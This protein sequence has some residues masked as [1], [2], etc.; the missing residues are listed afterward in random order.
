MEWCDRKGLRRSLAEALWSVVS[1]LDCEE[2]QWRFD[3]F[4]EDHGGA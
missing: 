2:R 4:Q 3:R 1:R